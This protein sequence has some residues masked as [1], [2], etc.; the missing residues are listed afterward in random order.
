M[1]V[2]RFHAL[3]SMMDLKVIGLWLPKLDNHYRV[4]IMVNTGGLCGFTSKNG[5]PVWIDTDRL[6]SN[7]K[8]VDAWGDTTAI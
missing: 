5:Q 1:N 2:S 4:L 3:P 8:T 6:G 7:K